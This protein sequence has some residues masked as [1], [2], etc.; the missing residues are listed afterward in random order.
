MWIHSHLSLH[1]GNVNE[2]ISIHISLSIYFFHVHSLSFFIF[3]SLFLFLF[4]LFC[5]FL[6]F[7]CCLKL[8][9]LTAHKQR[10]KNEQHEF[11]DISRQTFTHLDTLSHA[12][13]RKLTNTYLPNTRTHTHTHINTHKQH[14]RFTTHVNKLLSFEQRYFCINFDYFSELLILCHKSY[15]RLC[16]MYLRVWKLKSTPQS[17]KLSLYQLKIQ[18]LHTISL[19]ALYHYYELNI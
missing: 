4:L 2:L 5:L 8:L 17:R 9:L 14:H 19:A 13:I 7:L 18:C 11:K 6:C 3:I 16:K 1:T 15:N 10:G 12:H